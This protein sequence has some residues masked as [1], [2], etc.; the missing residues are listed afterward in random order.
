[1]GQIWCLLAPRVLNFLLS[2]NSP[3]FTQTS[4]Q[5]KNQERKHAGLRVDTEQFFSSMFS[6]KKELLKQ[7]LHTGLPQWRSRVC[8]HFKIRAIC[9]FDDET[10]PQKSQHVLVKLAKLYNGLHEI[11]CLK[12]IIPFLLSIPLAFLSIIIDECETKQK[13]IIK[14]QHNNAWKRQ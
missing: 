9:L 8:L 5:H 3:L 11:R 12:R 7:I 2:T 13:N 4:I 1:M 6:F 10:S 14:D